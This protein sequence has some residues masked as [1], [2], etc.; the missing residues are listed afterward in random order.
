MST[1]GI[2]ASSITGTGID[3]KTIV[4]QLMYLE[5]EPYR[6]MQT[7][8]AELQQMSSAWDTVASNVTYVYDAVESLSEASGFGAK[9]TSSTNS[10]LVTATATSSATVGSYDVVVTNLATTS[11]WVTNTTYSSTSQAL[12]GSPQNFTIQVGDGEAVT[13]NL[14]SSNNTLE[15]LKS[16]INR[17]DAGVAASIIKDSS[18][19]RL[20]VTSQT[21]G[22]E[23]E[24][25]I[26]GAPADL[27]L[28]AKVTAED[29]S[30]TVDGVDFTS[31]SNTV[32]D[33]IEGLTLKLSGESASHTTL[34]VAND[35]AS[36]NKAIS[37][38]VNSYNNLI[39]FINNQFTASEDPDQNSILAGDST[40]RDIQGNVLDLVSSSVPGLDQEYTTLAQIGIEMENDGKLSIDSGV[41][42]E[43]LENDFEQVQNLFQSLGSTSDN[44]TSYVTASADTKAGNYALSIS[45][46]ATQATEIST[47]SF[48]GSETFDQTLRISLNAEDALDIAV[49]G[50]LSEVV[51][52]IN[53][54]AEQEGLDF[55]A[56]D[57]VQG[58]NHYL[59]IYSLEYGSTQSIKIEESGGSAF[60]FSGTTK[61]GLDVIGSFDGGAS[62]TGVGQ[63]LTA[64]SGADSEGLAVRVSG[65]TTGDYGT[66]SFSRG[67]ADLLSSTLSYYTDTSGGPLALAKNSL[68]DQI[69]DIDDKMLVLEDQLAQK[70][71]MLLAEY[72]A[73]NQAL[74]NM[75]A[76]LSTIS[77]MTANLS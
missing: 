16:A 38:F 72:S 57:V 43:A 75:S 54:K 48:S 70:E 30:F 25:T 42:Q 51:S 23:G 24:I 32:S 68:A 50:T 29:A 63:L 47:S 55:R 27:G 34:T 33:A 58:G 46:V 17:A 26:S 12:T 4:S 6:Q 40:L 52:T 18:G 28:S 65:T 76:T 53:D 1:T 35:T 36:V 74:Q 71:D 41:L 77:Q 9:T 60:G 59:Q 62:T 37:N 11:S 8:K 61:S 22:T 31:S 64:P 20:L 69:D 2:S 45:Q 15:G 13:I 67:Y 3:V 44:R 73:A 5:R 39:T 19:Y 21:S 66:I 56:L 49:I 7:Q 14:D 10:D